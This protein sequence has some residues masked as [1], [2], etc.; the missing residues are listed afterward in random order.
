[1]FAENLVAEIET[2]S[3][4]DADL[5]AKLNGIADGKLDFTA[6]SQN[7]LKMVSSGLTHFPIAVK[8]YRI[9]FDKGEF[10]GLKLVTDTRTWF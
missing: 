3:A 9:D 5:I 2:D 6:S 4:L 1:M 8:A 10:K 7:Q